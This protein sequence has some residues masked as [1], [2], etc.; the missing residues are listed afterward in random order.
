[1]TLLR[2]DSRARRT[3]ISRPT[4]GQ[5]FIWKSKNPAGKILERDL[6]ITHLPLITDEWSQA[7]FADSGDLTVADTIVIGAPMYNFTIPAPQKGWIDHIVHSKKTFATTLRV[8]KVCWRGKSDGNNLQRRRLW[9]WKPHTT[10]RL[11]GTL[12]ALH[13]GFIGLADVTFIHAEHQGREGAD[14][15]RVAAIAQI[16][17]VASGQAMGRAQ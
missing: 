4:G 14:A 8:R 15:S 3:S 13:P 11:P 6:A 5:I 10:V 2:I 16:Q 17:Q 12:P 7:A 1:M 9:V